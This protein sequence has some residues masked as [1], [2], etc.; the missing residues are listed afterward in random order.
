MRK[1]FVLVE[2]LHLDALESMQVFLRSIEQSSRGLGF[3]LVRLRDGKDPPVYL[4]KD[5]FSSRHTFDLQGERERPR[6]YRQFSN[7]ELACCAL[8][9]KLRHAYGESGTDPQEIEISALGL[10]PGD[11]VKVAFWVDRSLSI[12]LVSQWLDTGQAPLPDLVRL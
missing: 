2:D 3:I 12:E 10:H 11:T 6:V 7:A 4:G 5:R 1:S 9:E 8:N